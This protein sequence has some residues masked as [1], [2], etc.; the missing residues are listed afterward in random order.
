MIYSNIDATRTEIAL[1][2]EAFGKNEAA[3]WQQ[4]H[5]TLQLIGSLSDPD[6]IVAEL[7][8]LFQ[9]G[10]DW[11][12]CNS[13]MLSRYV[14]AHSTGL[15][16]A[17]SGKKRTVTISITD[18]ATAAFNPQGDWFKW[19]PE[20]KAKNPTTIEEKIAELLTREINAKRVDRNQIREIDF[21]AIVQEVT[22]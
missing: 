3:G 22:A 6:D 13:A 12:M 5:D 17:V 19:K 15:K 7:V 18:R 14:A 11:K 9:A 16:I 8:T 20:P 1:N 2:L 21:E 4:M 10:F